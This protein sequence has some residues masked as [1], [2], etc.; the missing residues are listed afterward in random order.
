MRGNLKG[1]VALIVLTLASCSDDTSTPTPNQNPTAAFAPSCSV[2]G[3]TFTDGSTDDQAVTGWHWDFGDGTEPSTER[4]PVHTYASTAQ[5]RV[6]LRVTDAEGAQDS[7]FRDITVQA[8]PFCADASTPEEFVPCA[9][10]IPNGNTVSVTIGSESDCTVD[11]D[12]LRIVGAMPE[13]VFT[14]GC[15]AQKDLPIAMNA[16]NPF[17]CGDLCPYAVYLAITLGSDDPHRAAASVQQ[18]G[19]YPQWTIRLDDGAHPTD[20]NE[21]DFNDLVLTITA[22]PPSPW[23]Y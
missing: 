12:T 5:Y 11:S 7:T 15:H 8:E 23:D 14:D 6:A 10:D 3:C 18:E 1:T 13:N 2:L 9:I 4:N 19:G 21:P 22:T 20:P 16:G 17:V